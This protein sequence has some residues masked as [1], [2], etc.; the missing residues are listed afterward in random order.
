MKMLLFYVRHGEPTYNPDELTYLGHM[1]AMAVCKRLALFGVDKIYSSPCNR[2]LQT[3]EPLAKM[4]HQEITTLDFCNE[5]EAYRDF[6][7]DDPSY[8]RRFWCYLIPRIK[9]MFVSEEVR[10]LDREWYHYPGFPENRF[11][12]GVE[13]VAKETY[14]F[15][16][17]LGYRHDAEKNCYQAIRPN[18]DRVA[19]FA[20]EGFGNVFL[21][22]LLDIPYPI[23]CTRFGMHHSGLSVI[24]IK[25]DQEGYAIPQALMVGNDGH[26]YKEGLPLNYYGNKF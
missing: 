8:G 24:E 16:E 23:F 1:Q 9:R 12:E 22:T 18:D 15:M 6:S 26:L 10:K 2:A 25:E 7:V 19:L 13:R 21:S 17:S 14:A 11:K 3:A 4:L 5:N 20:H